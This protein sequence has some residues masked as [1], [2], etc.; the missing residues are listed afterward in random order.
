MIFLFLFKS[1]LIIHSFH[2]SGSSMHTLCFSSVRHSL[3]LRQ[4]GESNFHSDRE[5]SILFNWEEANIFLSPAFERQ[6]ESWVEQNA[7]TVAEEWGGETFSSELISRYTSND[8][9]PYNSLL[10]CESYFMQFF[11]SLLSTTT[12]P[13]HFTSFT[14]R[15]FLHSACLLHKYTRKHINSLAICSMV[16]I[17]SN[18]F[19]W[20]LSSRHSLPLELEDSSQRQ[21]FQSSPISS[22][23]CRVWR[24]LTVC[25]REHRGSF[26]LSMFHGNTCTSKWT[27]SKA[28]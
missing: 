26:T 20:S 28:R 7:A 21:S 19:Q 5:K 18:K 1:S 3:S 8:T 13:D 27:R 15:L 6:Q 22:A 23:Q 17:S 12:T 11:T 2:P 14:G 4:R 9:L 16:D 10:L 24:L 25:E